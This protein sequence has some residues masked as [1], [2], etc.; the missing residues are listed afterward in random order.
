MSGS[1]ISTGNLT[2]DGSKNL[3]IESYLKARIKDL[4]I[5]IIPISTST[6]F[7]YFWNITGL[8]KSIVPMVINPSLSHVAIQLNLEDS[9]DVLIIEYGQYLT[10]ES[11]LTKSIVVSGSS[12][13]SNEPRKV[14]NENI[15][16]YVNKDGVR[17]TIFTYEQ[18]LSM[19]KSN[20]NEKNL[21]TFI[22]QIIASQYYGITWN[23]YIKK[24]FLS[25]F[26]DS[27]GLFPGVIPF[28]SVDCD[29]QN[30]LSIK[31]LIENFKG[32]KWLAQKYNVISHNCQDFA[33]NVIK[34]LKAV[35]NKKYDKIRI[36]EKGKL[37]GKIS[38]Q[39]W[40]NEKLSITNTLGRIPVFGFFHD[41]IAKY[42]ILNNDE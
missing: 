27:I 24:Q 29:I 5:H 21:S 26:E 14:Y 1:L 15:Y 2:N 23:E 28:D 32:E 16:Y 37:P 30:K 12:N 7:K 39:L 9:K 38:F 4:T 8:L 36:V 42:I 33:Q 22:S 6:S 31:E 35:R 40:K 25:F 11:D 10:E 18:L 20:L 34:I 41:L 17:I 13:S 3:D 19:T